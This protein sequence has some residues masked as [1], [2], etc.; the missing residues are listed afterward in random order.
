MSKLEWRRLQFS[1]IGYGMI[2]SGFGILFIGGLF[3]AYGLTDEPATPYLNAGVEHLLPTKDD[4]QLNT[5]TLHVFLR[6]KKFSRYC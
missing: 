3:G 6:E 5:S 1:M 2:F 4:R